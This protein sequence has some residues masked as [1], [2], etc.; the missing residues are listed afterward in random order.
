MT[1]EAENTPPSDLRDAVLE[2]A[3]C[4]CSPEG[5]IS[6]DGHGKDE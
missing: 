3:V 5:E 4:S 6:P 1:I 2:N